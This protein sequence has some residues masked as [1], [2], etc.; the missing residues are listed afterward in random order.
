MKNKNSKTRIQIIF[1]LMLFTLILTAELY[2]MINYPSLIIVLAG[3]AAAD[4]VCLYIVIDGM[5]VLQRTR[6]SR[7]EE[8]YDSIF[9]SEK[10]SYIMLKK[11][12]VEIEERLDEL[13]AL[14]EIPREELVNA[15]KGIAK[16][17]INR[18]HE[19]TQALMS[20]YEQVKD[21]IEAFQ[22]EVENITGTMHHNYE[23]ALEFQ[24]SSGSTAEDVMQSKTKDM[25]IALKDMEIRLNNA[26]M[27]MQGNMVQA[28]MTQDGPMPDA[29]TAEG[30]VLSS[31]ETVESE[32]SVEPQEIISSESM[33]LPTEADEKVLA[34]FDAVAEEYEPEAAAALKSILEIDADEPEQYEELLEMESLM[35]SHPDAVMTPEAEMESAAERSA[36]ATEESQ[37]VEAEEIKEEIPESEV[38]KA[39]AVEEAEAVPETEVPKTEAVEETAEEKPEPVEIE[40]AEQKPAED[41]S[42]S[43]PPVEL[44]LSDP[45][46]SL[47]PDEIAALF[48]NM[49]A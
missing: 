41:K 48:A 42:T 43:E 22:K 13:E 8:Q 46:K 6:E 18:G 32:D 47:S 11:Y 15:Q 31:E 34:D 40:K 16:V 10:A 29:M 17:I 28:A 1:G 2:V 37:P 21:Q 35:S 3:M 4:L 26:I 7:Q 33:E 19:N 39:E 24:R 20:S 49:G 9:K 44:D 25:L 38:T 36:A 23:E 45:N 5:V 12:F 27:Q 14:V 30:A